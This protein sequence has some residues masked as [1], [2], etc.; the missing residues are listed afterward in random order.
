MVLRSNHQLSELWSFHGDLV[1][2]KSPN[3]FSYLP[4]FLFPKGLKPCF[5]P[6]LPSSNHQKT[7]FL[8]SKCQLR[9]WREASREWLQVHIERAKS[10]RFLLRARLVICELE[11]LF[12][13]DV[14]AQTRLVWK[15]IYFFL[16][17]NDDECGGPKL[18]GWW[19]VLGILRLGF[20][21]SST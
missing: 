9:F 1:L 5:F 13:C 19:D 2:Y 6:T 3:E 17:C 12:Y 8:E 21:G 7:R 4:P 16:G 20:L 10:K 14:N 18:D 15:F 11:N